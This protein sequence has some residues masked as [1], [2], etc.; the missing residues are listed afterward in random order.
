M[1]INVKYGEGTSSEKTSVRVVCKSCLK[2]NM[3][4]MARIMIITVAITTCTHISIHLCTYMRLNIN[5][6]S[7]LAATSQGPIERERE[8]ALDVK[9]I[10]FKEVLF[11]FKTK[12]STTSP[13]QWEWKKHILSDKFVEPRLCILK[14]ISADGLVDIFFS[15]FSFSTFSTRFCKDVVH[16]TCTQSKALNQITFQPQTNFNGIFL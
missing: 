4:C 11:L 9:A 12:V 13:S 3:R 8:K 5:L 6:Y 7:V 15:L 14:T 2:S 10:L 1:S 16:A